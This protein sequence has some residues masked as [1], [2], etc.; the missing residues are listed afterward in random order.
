MAK[1]LSTIKTR[2][3]LTIA[4]SMSV[5]ATA[6]A[7]EYG[8]RFGYF[9]L[10]ATTS[11]GKA[12]LSNIGLYSFTYAMNLGDHLEFRP[13]YSLYILGTSNID[14][15]YGPDIAVSYYPVT[16]NRPMLSTTSDLSLSLAEIY[17]PYVTL[18][19]RQRQFQSIQSGYAGLGISLGSEIHWQS[20]SFFSAELSISILRGPLQSEI[21]ET[22]LIGG[23]NKYIP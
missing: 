5:T 1:R 12:K 15:G 16:F 19:F 22:N 11:S 13:G 8:A 23:Y 17:R 7:G 18:G 2:Y 6:L 14:L 3:L 4:F 20:D 10:E 9:N 21:T